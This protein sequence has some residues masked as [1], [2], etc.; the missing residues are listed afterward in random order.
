MGITS[1][2]DPNWGK[3]SAN[4]MSAEVDDDSGDSFEREGTGVDIEFGNNLRSQER[5][6][7]AE[8]NNAGE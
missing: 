3:L 5:D 6:A 4:G 2:I 7:G 1:L 8:R